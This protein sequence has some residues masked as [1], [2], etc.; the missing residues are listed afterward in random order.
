[1]TKLTASPFILSPFIL[2]WDGNVRVLT[3]RFELPGRRL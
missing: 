2:H 1:M 3:L